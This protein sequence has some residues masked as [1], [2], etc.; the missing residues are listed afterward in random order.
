M[1]SKDTSP[2]CLKCIESGTHGHSPNPTCQQVQKQKFCTN[3][4]KCANEHCGKCKF[5]FYAGLN[6]ALQKI[7]GCQQFSCAIG[8]GGIEGAIGVSSGSGGRDDS[9]EYT[10]QQ[11]QDDVEKQLEMMNPRTRKEEEEVVVVIEE[12]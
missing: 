9:D 12:A 1:F 5:E 6:C 3:I 10:L 11:F 7:Q 8:G 4:A 2:N